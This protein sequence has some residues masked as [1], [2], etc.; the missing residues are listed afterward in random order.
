MGPVLC[1]QGVGSSILPK[2]GLVLP[3]LNVI[4]DIRILGLLGQTAEEMVQVLEKVKGIED[5]RDKGRGW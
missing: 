3:P 1:P 5:K 2:D 4:L